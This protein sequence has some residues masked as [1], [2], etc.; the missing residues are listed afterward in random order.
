[1]VG[2]ITGWVTRL[3]LS[4]NVSLLFT[5][6]TLLT[7]DPDVA[8]VTVTCIV[9]VTC[10]PLARLGTE[11]VIMPPPVSMGP[12]PPGSE[13]LTNPPFTRVSVMITLVAGAVP[14]LETTIW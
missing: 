3:L 10:E 9:A 5:E 7:V 13:P 12:V 11:K 8:A 2:V 6:A 14:P 1:M 4:G